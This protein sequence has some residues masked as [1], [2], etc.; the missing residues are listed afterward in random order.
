MREQPARPG[1]A[2]WLAIASWV[3]VGL[4]GAVSVALAPLS[5]P[6]AVVVVTALIWLALL[7]AMLTEQRNAYGYAMLVAI[8]FTVSGVMDVIAYGAAAKPA[9]AFTAASMVAFFAAI[10]ATR[11]TRRRDTRE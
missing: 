1:A 11:L 3:L 4:C 5:I 2:G 9:V 10:P 8:I 6:I 7:I